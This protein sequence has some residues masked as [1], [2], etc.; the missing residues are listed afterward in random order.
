MRFFIVLASLASFLVTV[1]TD[2]FIN[3][4]RSCTNVH[5]SHNFFLGATCWYA[6]HDHVEIPTENELD[7]TM[8]I[9][10]DQATGQM[11]WEV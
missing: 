4:D 6:D 5:L 8:C 11:Q 2:P 3:F 10:L 9:G 7:L 1:A